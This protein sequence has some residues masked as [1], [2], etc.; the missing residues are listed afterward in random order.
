MLVLVVQESN[1]I[2]LESMASPHYQLGLTSW[3]RLAGRPCVRV[4]P[5]RNHGNFVYRLAGAR[6]LIIAIMKAHVLERER[7]RD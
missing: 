6:K 3:A 1:M 7:E 5:F 2:L 4:H